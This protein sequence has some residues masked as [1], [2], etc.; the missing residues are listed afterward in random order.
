[1][2]REGRGC[3]A[4]AVAVLVPL[5]LPVPGREGVIGDEVE[6][7]LEAEWVNEADDVAGWSVTSEGEAEVEDCLALLPLWL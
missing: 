1:L 5:S 7:A 4:V 6:R 2:W 3:A